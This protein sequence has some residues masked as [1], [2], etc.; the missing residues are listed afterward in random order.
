MGMPTILDRHLQ[1]TILTTLAECYPADVDILTKY[2]KWHEDTKVTFANLNY[3][4]AHE[5][6]VMTMENDLDGEWHIRNLSISH[7]GLDFL[8]DD[9][10]L[11][12][13]LNV[14]TIKLH[15]ETLQA[16]LVSKVEASDLPTEQKQ[17][18]LCQIRELRGEAAKHLVTKIIDYGLDQGP[19]AMHWLTAAIKS[20]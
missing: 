18:L 16:L 13:I 9:G 6:V 19:A 14:V 4:W 3:L 1:R 11:S 5:L 8:S 20:L 15:P 7:K 2:H 17:S 12:A 10:G